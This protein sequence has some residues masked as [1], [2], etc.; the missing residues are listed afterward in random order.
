MVVV[1]ND[2][3]ILIDLVKLELESHFFSLDLD[4]HTTNL[5]LEELT[6]AQ[7][8]AMRPFIDNKRLTVYECTMD[9]LLV[10]MQL[11]A[12]K[13][14]LSTQDCSALWLAQQLNS[15]LLTSD[16]KLRKTAKEQ[17]LNVHGHLWVFDR[18]VSDGMLPGPLAIDKLNELC[19]IVNTKLGLPKDEIE[20]RKINWTK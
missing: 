3:N 17:Q 10:I 14:A 15:L 1:V 7:Q 5:I 16:N 19:S 11:E 13:P 8:N 4:F 9:D 18:L 20:K 12:Q 6:T 2:A